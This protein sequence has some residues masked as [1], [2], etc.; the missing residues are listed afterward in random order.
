MALIVRSRG[1]RSLPK[2]SNGKESWHCNDIA[3]W[4]FFFL[5]NAQLRLDMVTPPGNHLALIRL[6]LLGPR[7]N[8]ACQRVIVRMRKNAPMSEAAERIW[9]ATLPKPGRLGFRLT[10]MAV[11]LAIFTGV[12]AQGQVVYDISVATKYSGGLD[13]TLSQYTAF[14]ARVHQYL[15]VLNTPGIINDPKYDNAWQWAFHTTVNGNDAVQNMIAVPEP[16]AT[17]AVAIAFLGLVCGSEIRRRV[18]SAG[19]VSSC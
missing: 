8:Q 16:A 12:I 10:L 6:G 9:R 5:K 17:A 1:C 11:S 13:Q 3:T 18:T 14:D 19:S 4:G 2:H 7:P 15:N